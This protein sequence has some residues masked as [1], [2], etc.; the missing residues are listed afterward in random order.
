M[1][2]RGHSYNVIEVSRN[3][4]YVYKYNRRTTFLLMRYA[5]ISG[6]KIKMCTE[7]KIPYVTA[8]GANTHYSHHADLCTTCSN[9]RFS[10][11][12]WR[13]RNNGKNKKFG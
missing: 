6:D 12:E 3:K 1:V 11:K 10:Q 4:P 5:M 7:C 13:K 2:S 8:N 9:T